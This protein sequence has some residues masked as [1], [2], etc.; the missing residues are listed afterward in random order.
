MEI[1]EEAVHSGILNK[2]TKAVQKMVISLQIN[3][4]PCDI[5]SIWHGYQ[6]PLKKDHIGGSAVN[7][8]LCVSQPEVTEIGR[9]FVKLIGV[10]ATILSSPEIASEVIPARQAQK[11]SPGLLGY[12]QPYRVRKHIQKQQGYG[13]RRRRVV[14]GEMRQKQQNSP[15]SRLQSFDLQ[16]AKLVQGRWFIFK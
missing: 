4:I 6:I 7:N 16:I 10:N 8:E 3:F 11:V 13:T 2:S 1:R 15:T 5:P 12:V 9:S 14:G